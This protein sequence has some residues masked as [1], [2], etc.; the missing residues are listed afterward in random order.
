M[1][2]NQNYTGQ[3]FN[4]TVYINGEIATA[5]QITIARE[6]YLLERFDF[7]KIKNSVG[8]LN[9]IANTL[10]GASIGLFINMIAKLIGS[11][12]DTSIKFDN[13]EIYAFL[14]TLILMCIFFLIDYFVPNERKK[15]IKKIFN[16]FESNSNNN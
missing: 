5:P 7:E 1:Q 14:I 8:Y 2:N 9:G 16:H 13:W 10:L 15:I 12:I 4:Q 11:K 3:T 6:P